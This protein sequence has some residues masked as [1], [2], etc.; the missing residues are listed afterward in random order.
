MT[1][2]PPVQDQS[3][4]R[5]L[6]RALALGGAAALTPLARLLAAAGKPEAIV[7]GYGQLRPVKD[8][9]TGQRLLELPPGFSYRTFGWA[10]DPLA[11]GTPTP[12]AHD[13]MGVIGK[14]GGKLVLVRNH[15]LVSD[16]GAFG[17]EAICYDPAAGGGTVTLEVDARDGKLVRA[18][19]SLAG[20]LQNCSGGVTPW[21]TWLSCEEY[22]HEGAP[23]DAVGIDSA[24]RFMPRLTREHGFVFEVDPKGGRKPQLLYG[25]G[26]FRHEAAV[27]DPKS[28][29][30]YLTEDRET[31]SGFYRFV[32]AVSGKLDG[33]GKLQ[34]LRAKGASELV[35]GLRQGQTFDVEWVDIAD[36]GQGHTPGR[37]DGSGVVTQGMAAGG[38]PFTRLEGCVVGEDTVWFV[39]TNGG[40]ASTG[41]V[42]AYRPRDERITLHFES[43]GV[44]SVSY[45]DNL[46]LSPRGGM[47][48]CEDGHRL[49]QLLWGLSASGEL[50]PFARNNCE[51]RNGPH[52]ISGDFRGAEWAGSCYSPD[53][54][55]LFANVYH[56]GFTVAITGPWREGL[57]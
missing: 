16:T 32:P 30:C 51:I 11:D 9:T 54:K 42:F 24:A 7:G 19:P 48:L 57:V 12:A 14:R 15:E 5:L 10:G 53:G 34:M 43:T 28:G 23:T 40:D 31:H 44:D 21:G 37:R 46:C 4:R 25:L 35:R 47:L 49:G 6:G 33:A 50:F 39:A 3:R 20:T 17:G 52:G 2:R 13:G 22:L 26:Q 1:Q 55:W 27:V 38:T 18:V 45:P 41:Q 29:I 8:L 56:P 36:P